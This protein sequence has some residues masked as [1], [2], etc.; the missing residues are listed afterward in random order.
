MDASTE[1]L[2]EDAVN[3]ASLL[4]CDGSGSSYMV[5]TWLDRIMQEPETVK[6]YDSEDLLSDKGLFYSDHLFT[7]F[8]RAK[9]ITDILTVYNKP[10][11]TLY[12]VYHLGSKVCGHRAIVHGGLTSAIFDE[13]MGALLY[14]CRQHQ[15]LDFGAVFTARL[16][17]D[18]KKPV[19]AGT[20]VVCIAT[21]GTV[22]GRKIWVDS[23]LCDEP[24][25]TVYATSKALFV[26]PRAPEEPQTPQQGTEAPLPPK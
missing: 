23:K 5:P 25:G 15:Q 19:P 8:I 2:P 10:T 3:E 26:K 12:A 22:E 14:S 6:L 11:L 1:F 9:L 21:V 24:E 17:V 13:T 4:E 20:R 16:E 18:Y 7:H